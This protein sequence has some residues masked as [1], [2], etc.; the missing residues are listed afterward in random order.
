MKNYIIGYPLKN[1]RSIILWKKFFKKKRLKNFSMEP[2]LVKPKN[3][4][5]T[6]TEF[7][8]DNNF[9]AT[10]ITMPLK[11]LSAKYVTYEDKLSEI[12]GSINL[13]IR[14]K[15]KL[16]GYNTDVKAALKCIAKINKRSIM[17]FGLGGTGKPIAKVIGKKFEK[18]KIIC[19]S[20]KKHK[21]LHKINNIEVKKK[22]YKDD[23][24]NLTLF[25]NCSPLGSKL[26]K[27]LL[28]QSPISDH[29]LKQINKKAVVF[30]IVYQPNNTILRRLCKK[31]KI[32]YF[33]GLEMNTLQANI[34]LRIINRNL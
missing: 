26:K 17:I 10:A 33:N 16:I 19:I 25:I 29:Q 12:S 20:S 4:K 2:K 6:I 23:L 5:K 32:E 34:A 18:S 28:N 27:T 21:D 9:F 30:D 24:K 22:I 1:P 31:N 14:K 13:I 15:K 3:L 8:F 7:I 11:N